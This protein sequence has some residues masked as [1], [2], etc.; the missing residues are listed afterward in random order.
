MLC[1]P[2]K[3]IRF[4]RLI[5][6]AVEAVADGGG[7]F[8]G[9]VG[10][11]EVMQALLRDEIF[12]DDIGGVSA[13]ENDLELGTFGAEF[14][15]EFAAVQA[16]GHDEVGQEQTRFSW[17]CCLPRHRG[18]RTPVSAESDAGTL[19]FEDA[20]DEFAER[21]IVLDDEDG[22]VAAARRL[23]GLARGLFPREPHRTATAGD[24]RGRLSRGPTSHQWTFDPAQLIDDAVNGGEPEAGAFA[25]LLGG[26]ERFKNAAK[27]FG[28]D[29][30]AAI[31][32][33]EAD[34]IFGARFGLVLAI[35]RI[36]LGGGD[37][38]IANTG[39]L[40]GHGVAGVDD[41]VQLDLLDHAGVGFDISGRHPNISIA[42]AMSSPRMR[43]SIR[44]MLLTSWLRSS[45][46]GCMII[47]QAA[48]GEQLARR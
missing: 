8:L 6:L 19:P 42:G 43:P 35:I 31:S 37:L 46:F 34:E 25:D 1:A 44:V 26:E 24:R 32:D 4:A 48:E 18:P 36:G 30:A 2:Q 20:A 39:R 47:W 33:G 38:L 40:F 41:E 28:I 15:G 7:E 12:S 3:K 14:F 27:R 5:G 23:T 21:R 45:R 22:F 9:V 13:G 10:F 17:L 11:L 29:P 16:I